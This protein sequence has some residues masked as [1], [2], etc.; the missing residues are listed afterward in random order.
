M[1]EVM[2]TQGML[3]VYRLLDLLKLK[4]ELP[5]VLE[6]DNSD[7]VDIVN[8]WSVESRTKHVDINKS[9]IFL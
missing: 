4:V 5:I 3:Y 9:K 2:A 7:A 1:A 6:M 8:S